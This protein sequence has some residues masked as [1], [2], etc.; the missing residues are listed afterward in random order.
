MAKLVT[1]EMEKINK[2]L[3]KERR[4]KNADRPSSPGREAWIRLKRNRLAVAG[5][6]ILIVL[7]LLAIFAD[8][9]APY[10]YDEQNLN[11][12]LLKP[13]SAHLFG[14]DNYGRDIFSRVI[15]GTRISFPIGL[16]CTIVA[17]CIGGFF[18]S[19]AAFYGGKV[20]MIIMRVM[21][22]F[23]SIPPTLMAIAV[24]ASLGTG[25]VNLVLAI[26]ISTCPGRS[27][28]VRS[29]LLA[30]KNNEY[31]ESA[32]ATGASTARQILKYMLPNALGPIL[33]NMTFNVAT[34]ILTVASMSYLGLGIPAPT[35][36]WGAML[37]AG[38]SFL[39]SAP[40]LLIFPGIAIMVT[41]LA[42]NLFGDGLRDALDPRL[43]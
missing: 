7:I 11:E 29:S 12:T 1:P 43:K 20:D 17:Y 9:I 13:S 25:A 30:V 27:R 22:V 40:H 35:P 4:G 8:V 18:G 38:K 10:G 41:V 5:M 6:I 23:Q 2:R 15:Y 39:R 3:A 24:A 42:L 19:L 28:I 33:T 31:L 26:A 16:I 14:T 21:D 32:R 34:A 37:S 36:E